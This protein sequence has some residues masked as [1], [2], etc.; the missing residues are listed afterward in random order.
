MTKL[1]PTDRQKIVKA[2]TYDGSSS[3]LDYKAH[4][5]TCAEINNCTNTEKELHVYLA[6]TLR[7]QAQSV[8]GNL[9][10]KSKD[11]G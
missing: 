4:F 9:S 6:V 5:E 11:N 10:D 8:M 1:L 2:A 3:W 7:V